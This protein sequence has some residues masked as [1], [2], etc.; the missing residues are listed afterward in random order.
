MQRKNLLITLGVLA[1][2]WCCNLDRLQSK[3]RQTIA[4]AA[5][6]AAVANMSGVVAE[7][8]HAALPLL[9]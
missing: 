2:V 3:A 8:T 5:G 4:S 6:K 1:A 7:I 9:N